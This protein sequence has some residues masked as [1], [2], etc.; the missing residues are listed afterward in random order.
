LSRSA[1]SAARPGG[2]GRRG[3]ELDPA[4]LRPGGAGAGVEAGRERGAEELAGGGEVVALGP[5]HQREEIEREEG[6]GIQ[7]GGDVAQRHPR[8]RGGHDA[9][10]VPR[11]ARAPAER[12]RHAGAGRH[13]GLER[14]RDAVGEGPAHRRRDGDLDQHG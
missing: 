10:D 8:R 2:A 13:L 14:G 11:R 6:E 9:G 3:G 12:H 1:E 5:A 7:H 4:P